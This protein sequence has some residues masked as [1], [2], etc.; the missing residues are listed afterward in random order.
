MNLDYLVL[1]PGLIRDWKLS[2]PLAVG[3]VV[4]AENEEAVALDLMIRNRGAAALTVSIDGQPVVTVDAGD[5]YIE[6]DV[7]MRTIEVFS[8]VAY[9]LRVN[10]IKFQTLKALGVA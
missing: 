7:I 6:N 3:Q 2:N 4:K 10:G 1:R 5:V 9:D 8:A